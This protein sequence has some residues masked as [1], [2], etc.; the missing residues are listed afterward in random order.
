[1]GGKKITTKLIREGESFVWPEKLSS[2]RR[3]LL[4]ATAGVAA[5]GG[6]LA[7]IPIVCSLAPSDRA[8]AAGAPIVVDIDGLQPGTVLNATWQKKPVWVLRRTPEMLAAIDTVSS[9]NALQDS[10]SKTSSQQDDCK[11]PYRSI[12]KEYLVVIASCTHL[13]CLPKNRFEKGTAEGMFPSWQGGFFCPCH[14]SWFDLAGRVYKG[15]PAPINLAVPP[16]HYLT[17]TKI[18]IGS[19]KPVA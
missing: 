16:H 10:E 15:L 1:M 17:D 4:S 9:Q 7:T 5:V 2:K 19:S 6:A 11:N 18:F 13:G 3:N 12:K 8:K 14:S